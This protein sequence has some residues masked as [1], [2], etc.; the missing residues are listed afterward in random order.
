M[1]GQ[2]NEKS[3]QSTFFH[4]FYNGLIISAIFFCAQKVTFHAAIPH[5]L[6]CRSSPFA[7]GRL[8]FC[9]QTVKTSYIRCQS[10]VTQWS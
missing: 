7:V 1:N 5:L 6:A 9:N 10:V 3:L 4:L 8:S 2:R